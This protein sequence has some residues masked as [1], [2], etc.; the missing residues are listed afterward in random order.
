L[1]DKKLSSSLPSLKIEVDDIEN[2]NESK[3]I[4]LYL[5]AISVKPGFSITEKHAY[6]ARLVS[7]I[8][9]LVQDLGK[10]GI[11]IGTIA[12]RSNMPDGIRLMRHAGFTEV[13][14]LTPMPF[15]L[16]YAE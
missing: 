1:G 5:H 6:G 3:E 11:K 14:P 8:I 10:R 15:F 9:E 2:F 13:E 4:D 16:T 12:A 7:G